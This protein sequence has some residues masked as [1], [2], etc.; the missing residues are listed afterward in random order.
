MATAE[1]TAVARR[2]AATEDSTAAK[3]RQRRQRNNNT[4]FSQSHTY[5]INDAAVSKGF[6]ITRREA[7]PTSAV[8]RRPAT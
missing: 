2:A 1:S 3:Q 6:P 4:N 7:R 5:L 8:S